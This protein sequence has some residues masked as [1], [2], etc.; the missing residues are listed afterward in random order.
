M[1]CKKCFLSDITKNAFKGSS[2]NEH[3]LLLNI[4]YLNDQAIF[5]SKIRNKRV[6]VLNF[7]SFLGLKLKGTILVSDESTPFCSE[8]ILASSP[9]KIVLHFSMSPYFFIQ[10]KQRF[11]I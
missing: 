5:L 9:V 4:L 7:R 8:Y 11:S 6:N 10:H 2:L 3:F 1:C